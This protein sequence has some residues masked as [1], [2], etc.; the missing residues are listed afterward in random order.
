[1]TGF[2]RVESESALG[3]ISWELRSVN[4]RYLDVQFRLPEA[5]RGSEPAL[6]ARAAR[7]LGRGKVDCTLAVRAADEQQAALLIDEA[8]LVMLRDALA[9]AAD[10]CPDAAPAS[11]M[12]LLRWPGIIAERQVDTDALAQIAV[13][14]FDEALSELEAMRAREGE[15]LAALLLARCDDIDAL[16]AAVRTRRPEVLAAIRTRM[17]DRL[18][19]LDVD[20][21]PARLETELAIIAQKLDVDEEL[22]RLD[23]HITE[24]RSVLDSAEPVGRRLDFLMQELNREANTLGSKSADA[25]TTRAAVDMKVAIEQMREQ[26][27]NVE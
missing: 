13:R 25:E 27:Q 22:D 4:H 15:R 17:R 18:A 14:L 21:D 11:T 19:A 7:R 9:A 10:V 8:R 16:T 23:A 3:T 1:M 24:I 5:V 2:A 12:D 26:I 20:A 6:R